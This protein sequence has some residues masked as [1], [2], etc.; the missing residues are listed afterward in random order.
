MAFT[1]EEFQ[2]VGRPKETIDEQ[3]ER[4]DEGEDQRFLPHVMEKEKEENGGDHTDTAH[5]QP[6]GIRQPR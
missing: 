5:R 2:S 6:V 3:E 4:E 1:I